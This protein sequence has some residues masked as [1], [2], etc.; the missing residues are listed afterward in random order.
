MMI[1][2]LLLRPW[3]CLMNHDNAIPRTLADDLLTIIVGNRHAG[4]LIGATEKTLT[5]L[6]D[7]G[8]AVA[9]NKSI[10][11][12]S[13]EGGKKKEDLAEILTPGDPHSECDWPPQ[14][15]DA[16]KAAGSGEVELSQHQASEEKL[17]AEI[18]HDPEANVNN[19]APF[20]NAIALLEAELQQTKQHNQFEICDELHELNVLLQQ[21]T[22]LRQEAVC[23]LSDLKARLKNECEV[24]HGSGK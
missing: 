3:M 9:T 20:G 16:C 6:Q 19:I 7:M 21:E 8:A 14:N 15:Y 4:R 22:R 18:T 2:A 11:F 10:L 23:E 13:T 12:S 5:F 24:V 17:A 1:V